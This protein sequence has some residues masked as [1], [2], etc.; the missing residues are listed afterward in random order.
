[1]KTISLNRVNKYFPIN[2]KKGIGSLELIKLIIKNKNKNRK[3]P[4]LK[5]ISFEVNK[6]EIVGI[7]GRNGSGKSTLLKCIAKIY[8]PENGFVNTNGKL[9]YLSGL[10]FG[11]NKRLTMREN[12]YLT[13]NLLGLN[14][15]K[16]KNLLEPIMA[17]SGLR[18]YIDV[19]T[20]KFSSGMLSRLAFSTTL[21]CIDNKKANVILLD[22]VMGGGG[23]EEFKIKTEK[24]MEQLINCGATVLIVSHSM[25]IIKRYCKRTIL[26]DKGK[27]IFDGSSD[28]AIEKYRTLEKCVNL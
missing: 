13:G 6:G 14:N 26:I 15:K 2:K 24:K 12:I 27:I 19:E 8:F 9:F 16:I 22:E 25:E 23:D 10:N 1:M 18:N 7:I 17:F 28:K 5:D 20:S 21:Q 11:I 3:K 4:I